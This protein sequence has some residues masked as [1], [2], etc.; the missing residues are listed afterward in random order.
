VNLKRDAFEQGK[1][2]IHVGV[3]FGRRRKRYVGVNLGRRKE[4]HI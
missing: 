3:N 2:K 1:R 4:I